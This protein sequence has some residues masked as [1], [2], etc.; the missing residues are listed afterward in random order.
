MSLDLYLIRGSEFLGA[1]SKICHS[2]NQQFHEGETV[3]VVAN[4]EEKIVPLTTANVYRGK[5]I[6][7]PQGVQV[8][9]TEYYKVQVSGVKDGV[10]LGGTQTGG[11]RKA[12][13][14][15]IHRP[16]FF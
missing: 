10:G 14:Q 5:I 15:F 2:K 3:D 7:V 4:P 9:E 1:F 11:F 13:V 16:V 12:E 6:E 8:G